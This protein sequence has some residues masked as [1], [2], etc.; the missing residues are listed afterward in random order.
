[1]S[2]ADHFNGPWEFNASTRHVFRRVDPLTIY[3]IATMES[4]ID[5]LG[6]MIAAAPELLQVVECMAKF[7]GRNNNAA[8]KEMARAAIAKALGN[9]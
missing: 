1:M 9:A 6:H 2:D 7:D 8:L 4:G 5:G 3:V